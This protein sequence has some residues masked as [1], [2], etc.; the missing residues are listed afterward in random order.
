MC[1]I[2]GWTKDGIGEAEQHRF[3][4]ATLMLDH[5]GP[6]ARAV[7]RK[8][9]V[10]L[11]HTRL[12]IVDLSTSAHQPMESGDGLTIT[13]N[14]EIYNHQHL[15]NLLR[16]HGHQFATNSDTEVLLKAYRQWGQKMVEKIEGMFSFCIYDEGEECLFLARDPLGKKPLYYSV[17]KNGALIFASETRALLCL[18]EDAPQRDEEAL[19][20]FLA[21]GYI[22]H[23]RT[24][25]KVIRQVPPGSTLCYHL[26]TCRVSQSKYFNLIDFFRHK[27]Q[28]PFKDTSEALR[29]ALEKAVLKR[30]MGD[31]PGGLFLSGGLD[32]ALILAIIRKAS[33]QRFTPFHFSFKEEK[34]DESDKAKS[35]ADWLKC[36]L[37]IVHPGYDPGSEFSS[38]LEEMDYIPADNAIFPLYLLSKQAV[39]EVKFVLT[40]DGAD[41]LLGGY[42]TYKADYWNKRLR[43][44]LTCT[45][46]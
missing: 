38:L 21:L 22:L 5:R 33:G 4:A 36:T 2:I 35:V 24:P 34:Y 16:Q 27:H 20:Q 28:L 30:L 12:M 1:G 44:L 6:D 19:H 11:G 15:R 23:P 9:N 32:S 18:L 7:R 37:T 41:E 3:E 26:P 39:K 46:L 10:L 13:Y 25:Y 17:N 40:G 14:G 42:A 31:V 29:D 8:G 43:H 45:H